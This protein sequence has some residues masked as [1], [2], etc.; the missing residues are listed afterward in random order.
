LTFSGIERS[1]AALAGAT[2]V[3][4]VSFK[5]KRLIQSTY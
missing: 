2:I 1:S 3:A 5:K 4:E